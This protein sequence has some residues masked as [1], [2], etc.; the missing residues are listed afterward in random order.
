MMEMTLLRSSSTHLRSG[1]GAPWGGL[2]NLPP[3]RLYT[4]LSLTGTTSLVG[5]DACLFLIWIPYYFSA[6]GLQF[7]FVCF[8][9]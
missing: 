8:P 4:D 1:C 9:Y 2:L 7:M 5:L 3:Q 6:P